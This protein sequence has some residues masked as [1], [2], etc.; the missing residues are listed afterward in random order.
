MTEQLIK[1]YEAKYISKNELNFKT[2][3]TIRVYSKIIEGEKERV[4]V[5]SGIVIAI[6]GSGLSLT[7]NVYRNAYGCSMERVFLLH[8]P[9]ITKIEV[10]KKGKARKSKLYYL[11]G[12]SGKKAKVKEQL[13]KKIDKASLEEQKVNENIEKKAK[14]NIKSPQE[15]L[16]NEKSQQKS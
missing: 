2:G 7:F 14:E 11:R 5:F 3:D 15:K 4:Q 12:E 1:D 8:S 13:M 16:N 10:Q 6:K 9:R